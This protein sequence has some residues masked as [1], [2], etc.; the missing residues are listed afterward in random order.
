MAGIRVKGA[1]APFV[2][3]F[4]SLRFNAGHFRVFSTWCGCAER[5][6]EINQ[7]LGCFYEKPSQQIIK[8]IK[9]DR[10]SVV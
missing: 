5:L 6:H 10:K 9:T 8:I 7:A 1:S 3:L 4:L 2:E